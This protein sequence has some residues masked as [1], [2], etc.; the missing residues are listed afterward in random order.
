MEFRVRIQ[1]ILGVVCG[2]GEA[3]A[4]LEAT[5]G[6]GCRVWGLG[7]RI[8][9]MDFRSC[10]RIRKG[11]CPSGSDSCRTFFLE[12]ARYSVSG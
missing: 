4:P 9:A 2:Q 1:A 3:P 5:P 10:S 6:I 12:V 11:A 8:Q 7:V